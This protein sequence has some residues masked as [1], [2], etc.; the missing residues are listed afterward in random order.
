LAAFLVLPRD[1]PGG[2]SLNSIREYVEYA[3]SRAPGSL[4]IPIQSQADLADLWQ[5]LAPCCTE[6]EIQWTDGTRDSDGLNWY[7]PGQVANLSNVEYEEDGRYRALWTQAT[8]A[9]WP[10][11]IKLTFTL[12]D[13]AL[14]QAERSQSEGNEYEVICTIGK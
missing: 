13:I 5:A 9:S 6:L 10:A 1:D 8:Q 11:A 12:K 14:S 3:I 2:G 7:G 4:T